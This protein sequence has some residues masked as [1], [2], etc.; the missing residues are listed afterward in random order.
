MYVGVDLEEY[1]D[2]DGVRWVRDK[3]RPPVVN[4]LNHYQ[5]TWKTRFNHFQRYTDVK[6]K[7]TLSITVFQILNFSDNYI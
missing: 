7:G 4:L 5:C 6:P 2:E 1:V 3:K